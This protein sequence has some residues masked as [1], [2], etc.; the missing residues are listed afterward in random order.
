AQ[1]EARG[2]GTAL[3]IR[4]EVLDAVAELDFRE[5]AV[6]AYPADFRERALRAL[7]TLEAA[8]KDGR[9][10]VRDVLVSQR[11]LIQ[12]LQAEITAREQLALARLEVRRAAGLPLVEEVSP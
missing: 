3:E 11:S 10:G 9:L 5:Q 2:A 12:G 1:G 4:G 8:L 6:R 7:R